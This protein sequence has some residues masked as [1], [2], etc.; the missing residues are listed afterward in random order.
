[1]CNAAGANTCPFV[2]GVQQLCLDRGGYG[3][4]Y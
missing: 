2:A 1:M 3:M 4:C